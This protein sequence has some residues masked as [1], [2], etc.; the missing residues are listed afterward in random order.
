MGFLTIFHLKISDLF[1]RRALLLVLLVLPAALGMVAGSANIVNHDPV[2]RLAIVDLDRSADSQLL[3][4][5]LQVSGWQVSTPSMGQAERQLD[6]QVLD[7]IIVIR[8]G[9]AG[10]LSDLRRSYVDF[11]QSEGSLVTFAVQETVAAI[12]L[13]MFAREHFTDRIE[14]LYSR[15]GLATP[16]GVAVR[17][18]DNLSDYAEGIARFHVAYHS[19]V[20]TVPTVALVVSDYSMEIFF[21]SVYAVAGSIALSSGAL[22]KRLSAAP[23]GLEKNYVATLL[24]LFLLGITQIF[25]YTGFMRLVMGS[26]VTLR[27]LVTL[28][29]YLLLMLGLGQMAFLLHPSHRMYFSLLVLLVLAVLGGTFFQL[30]ELLLRNLGQYTPNGWALFRIKQYD[31]LPVTAPLVLAGILLVAGIPVQRHVAAQTED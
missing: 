1:S 23:Y 9:F 29:V 15:Q 21:L 22:R 17:F 25:L 16:A 19:R 27:D 30:P 5:R 10:S 11:I 18:E 7:G 31:V 4:E 2:I 6:R 14:A 3:S 24:V 26:P 12:V 20:T 8:K 28:A 13:P